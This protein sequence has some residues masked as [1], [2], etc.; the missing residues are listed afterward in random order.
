MSDIA[1][2]IDALIGMALAPQLKADGYAR[3]GRTWRR[4]GGDGILVVNIQASQFNAG[5]DGR[6]TMNLGVSLPAPHRLLKERDPPAAPTEYQ[7]DLRARIGELIGDG[8]HWWRVDASTDD[9]ALG[10]EIAEAWTRHGR[11]WLEARA[12]LAG[13]ADFPCRGNAFAQPALL[14]LLGR[15]ED[16]RRLLEEAVASWPEARR[17]IARDM[18]DAVLRRAGA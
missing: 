18:A 17:A 14:L 4:R 6:F 7:C 8:D 9:L 15:P 13:A 5:E 11:P 16:A 3:K 12:T 1:A 2:R 10:V